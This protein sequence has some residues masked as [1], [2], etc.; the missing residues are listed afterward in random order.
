M[1][2]VPG[3]EW[4][5]SPLLRFSRLCPPR[6]GYLHT[7]PGAL[8]HTAPQ[9]GLPSRELSIAGLR[10]ALQHFAAPTGV[11]FLQH[12]DPCRQVNIPASIP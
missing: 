7:G 8:L 3:L 9:L 5:N 11:G 12:L 4:A 1:C 6:S 10:T 2:Q